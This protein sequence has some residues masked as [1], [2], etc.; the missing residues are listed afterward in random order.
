MDLPLSSNQKYTDSTNWLSIHL[1]EY[2]LEENQKGAQKA[3]HIFAD[4]NFMPQIRLR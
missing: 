2:F 3:S 4:P 1:Q